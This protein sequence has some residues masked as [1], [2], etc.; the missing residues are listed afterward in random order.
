MFSAEFTPAETAVLRFIG[1]EI[2]SQAAG[3]MQTIIALMTASGDKGSA[4]PHLSGYGR[5]RSSNHLSYDLERVPEYETFLNHRPLGHSQMFCHNASFPP[6]SPVAILTVN[7]AFVNLI[8]WVVKLNVRFV[9]LLLLHL[10]MKSSSNRPRL[11]YTCCE[12]MRVSQPVWS[13]SRQNRK[14]LRSWM[15]SASQKATK[16]PHKRGNGA[17]R[18]GLL[19]FLRIK[20]SLYGVARSGIFFYYRAVRCTY[21]ESSINSAIAPRNRETLGGLS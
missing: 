13:I 7:E 8:A 16:S 18:N 1:T 17:A 6:D 15:K 2:P 11:L 5:G 3:E 19:H 20:T 4:L 21:S 9:R 14:C 10:T 12:K